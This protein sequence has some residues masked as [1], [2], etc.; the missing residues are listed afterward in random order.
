MRPTR[1]ATFALT[2]SAVA[3]AVLVANAGTQVPATAANAPARTH[4]DLGAY[5]VR[6]MGCHDC[7][8]PWKMGPRAPRWT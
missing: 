7:H 4:A 8:T 5:L 6:T 2:T 1:F 3:L